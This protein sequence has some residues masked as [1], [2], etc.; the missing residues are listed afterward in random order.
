MG[1]DARS[2][3]DERSNQDDEKDGGRADRDPG[4]LLVGG[5][6]AAR[7]LQAVAMSAN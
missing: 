2:G 5:E 3:E 7:C 4:L 1:R 6:R